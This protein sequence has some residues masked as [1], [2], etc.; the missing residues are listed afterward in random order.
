MRARQERQTV[1]RLAGQRSGIE[2]TFTRYHQVALPNQPVKAKFPA[3]N[4]KPRLQSGIE[5]GEQ[6]KTAA[7]SRTSSGAHGVI[8]A[9]A[10]ARHPG[11]AAQTEIEFGQLCF[12]RTF[13][14]PKLVGR[15]PPAKERIVDINGRCDQGP[16]PAVWRFNR[17]Q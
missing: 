13:L 4:F 8:F 12:G 9:Q 10:F 7:A 11:Q 15:A 5:E 16:L 2:A 1:R 6:A 14:R 3:K 17:M